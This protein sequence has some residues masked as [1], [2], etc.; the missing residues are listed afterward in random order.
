[1]LSSVV[2]IYFI[3]VHFLFCVT[4]GNLVEVQNAHRQRFVELL[5]SEGHTNCGMEHQAIFNSAV[6]EL[7]FKYPAEVQNCSNFESA[8]ALYSQ[9]IPI[10]STRTLRL[11]GEK[12]INRIK[13]F[14]LDISR[15]A[16]LEV[17][18]IDFEQVV[19]KYPKWTDDTSRNEENQVRVEKDFEFVR[20]VCEANSG[21]LVDGLVAYSL[22]TLP[23][24]RH[25]YCKGTLSML[26]NYSLMSDMS[27]SVDFLLLA[28]NRLNATLLTIHQLGFAHGD[29]KPGNIFVFG[30]Q[31]DLGDFGGS[32]RI[33]EQ[34][35]E[36]SGRFLPEDLKTV[37]VLSV[38]CDRACLCTTLL[39]VMGL[40][41]QRYTSL[42]GLKTHVEGLTDSECN[43][44][45]K[46][47][48]LSIC[49]A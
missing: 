17:L 9:Y 35:I 15:Y 26:Y 20:S 8:R 18:Q 46:Q 40:G 31:V 7:L 28:L 45:V 30:R 49:F 36:Y 24:M 2:L 21:A 6:D 47:S 34:I 22:R 11:Y 41:L 33:G 25:S 14:S 27:L 16:C 12:E 1:M 44:M 38:V 10:H 37:G 32:G 4:G 42:S 29:I 5:R 13:V 23:S 43:K 3:C 39:A 48:L 19:F